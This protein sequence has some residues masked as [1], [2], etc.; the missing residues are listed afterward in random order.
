M[1]ILCK[2]IVG[3]PGGSDGKELACNAGDLGSIPG[4]GRFPGEGNHY[5]LQYS[6]VQNS[7]DRG[8]WWAAIQGDAKSETQLSD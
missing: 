3:F 7:M 5:P 4:S 1:Y 2:Y 8:A 6:F